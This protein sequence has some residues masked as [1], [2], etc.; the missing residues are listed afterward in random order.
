MVEQIEP[1]YHVLDIGSPLSTSLGHLS[2]NSAANTQDGSIYGGS[3]HE[4]N[5]SPQ[6]PKLRSSDPILSSPS[7]DG[8]PTEKEGWV[9]ASEVRKD[10]RNNNSNDSSNQ[11][12][13][14]TSVYYAQ[15]IYDEYEKMKR[16]T[17]AENG[18]CRRVPLM[19]NPLPS[20][21]AKK[22]SNSTSSNGPTTPTNHSHGGQQGVQISGSN[23]S[24]KVFRRPVNGGFE[25]EVTAVSFDV[26]SSYHSPPHSGGSSA[27]QTDFSQQQQIPSAIKTLPVN[28]HRHSKSHIASFAG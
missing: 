11:N 4:A 24:L 12:S 15:I 18:S 5:I 20:S 28:Y 8:S 25:S 13:S 1:F 17:P 16:D 21:R 2:H 19:I 7:E 27:D 22:Q 23:T 10:D 14:Q 6:S 26:A 3:D 9:A